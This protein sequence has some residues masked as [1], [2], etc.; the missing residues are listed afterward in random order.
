MWYWWYSPRYYNY[1]TVWYLSLST[2]QDLT[3]PDRTCLDV[4]VV[5][6]N[7]QLIIDRVVLP[8]SIIWYF[9]VHWNQ[10]V[11]RR[12]HMFLFFF[13]FFFFLFVFFFFL[14]SLYYSIEKLSPVKNCHCVENVLGST[15]H[16][17]G[18]PQN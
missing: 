10:G 2:G 6:L 3:G 18:D 9:E 14:D 13:F 15:Q 8:P 11:Y 17:S 4:H 7:R 1:Y 5:S 12:I 16:I